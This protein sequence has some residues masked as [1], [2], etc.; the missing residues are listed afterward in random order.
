MVRVL[1]LSFLIKRHRTLLPAFTG[2]V[3][4]RSS[5]IMQHRR[6]PTYGRK[7]PMVLVQHILEDARKRLVILGRDAPIAAAAAILV[8][9]DT[10]LVVVCDSEGIAVGV[11]SK[12]DIIRAVA[13][14]HA[15]AVK[16]TAGDLM[17]RS[18]LSCHMS[19][20]LQGVWDTMSA[21]SVRSV[22]VLDDS[23]RPQGV[24]HARDLARALLNEVGEEELL[25]R[26][27]VLGIGYQ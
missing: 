6:Q 25:L 21:R 9:P 18:M 15:D 11:V 2:F 23:G 13:R 24:V 22:P 14:A 19:Q 4:K 20:T 1:R 26:N 7:Q 8:N 17:T 3:N 12:S 27:Y 16:M 10:P 5:Y